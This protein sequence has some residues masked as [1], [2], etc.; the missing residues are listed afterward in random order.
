MLLGLPGPARCQ[1]SADD[2]VK[3][4]KEYF[5]RGIILFKA[6]DYQGALENF[7]IS[8]NLRPH[9]K[10]RL[11][12]GICLFNLGRY[13]EAG[14]ELE[15]FLREGGDLGPDLVAKADKYLG[16]IKVKV[17]RLSITVDVEGIL[18]KIDDADIGT[19]PLEGGV[20]VEPGSHEIQAL[21]DGEQVWAGFASVNAGEDQAVE[22]ALDEVLKAKVK[23]EKEEKGKKKEEKKGEVKVEGKAKD[24]GAKKTPAKKPRPAG[25]KKIDGAYF[26]ASLALTLAALIGGG[27]SGAVALSKSG[28]L[29]DLDSGCVQE[30]CN[31]SERLYAGYLKKRGDTYDSAKISGQLSTGFFIASGAL[32]AVT[33]VLLALS[34]PWKRE[35]EKSTPAALSLLPCGAPGGLGMTVSF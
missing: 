6:G 4:S 14:N 21:A 3:Y 12:I 10:L 35:S 28:E 22:I 18:L 33:I 16:E 25:K 2:S 15:A 31:L 7:T 26:Y 11:N 30:G 8:Y 17:G 24:T 9:A 5:D 1:E 13:A 32:A 19:S 29:D 23:A 20:F 27:A 34:K